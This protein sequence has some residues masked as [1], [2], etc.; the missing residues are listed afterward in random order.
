[1]NHC[2]PT[3]AGLMCLHSAH[4]RRMN[5]LT[6][7]QC[8]LLLDYS[9]HLLLLLLLLFNCNEVV[10]FVC[11]F[12]GWLAALVKMKGQENIDGSFVLNLNPHLQTLNN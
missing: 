4:S 2:E 12:V 1:M 11:L 10:F 7:R 9:E 3:Y 6:R 8:G 5:G